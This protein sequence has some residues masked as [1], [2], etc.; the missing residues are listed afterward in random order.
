MAAVARG[1]ESAE[2]QRAALASAAPTKA[3]QH[4]ANQTAEVAAAA[5]L[6]TAGAASPS[7]WMLH[8]VDCHLMPPCRQIPL[9]GRLLQQLSAASLQQ[10][11]CRLDFHTPEN[12]AALCS[13]TALRYRMLQ[14]HVSVNAA[15]GP[16]GL[17]GCSSDVLGP[18]SALQQLMVLKLVLDHVPVQ[19]LAHLKLPQLTRLVAGICRAACGQPAQQQQQQQQASIQQ[20][21]TR[22]LQL[23]LG[24][25]MSLKHLEVKG[26][27]L[28]HSDQ[29]PISLVA[30]DWTFGPKDDNEDEDNECSVQPLLKLTRLEELCMTFCEVPPATAQ[31]RELGSLQQVKALSIKDCS[32]GATFAAGIEQAWG[33]LPLTRLELSGSTDGSDSHPYTIMPVSALQML[34]AMT[35]LESLTLSYDRRS[36]SFG[37]GYILL[38]VTFAQLAATLRPLTA[39]QRLRLI[40]AGLLGDALK[41][42][43]KNQHP[44]KA[45]QDALGWTQL[46]Q[47]Q[48]MHSAGANEQPALCKLQPFEPGSFHSEYG[49][50]RLTSAMQPALFEGCGAATACQATASGAAVSAAAAAAGA[51]GSEVQAALLSHELVRQDQDVLL[52]LLQSCKELHPEVAHQCAGQMTAVLRPHRAEHAVAFATWL[53]RHAG[54]LQVL[55]LQL[56][57]KRAE[58]VNAKQAVY[59]LVG[60]MFEQQKQLQGLQRFYLT[61]SYWAAGILLQLPTSLKVLDLTGMDAASYKRV[62]ALAPITRLQQLTEQRIGRVRPYQLASMKLPP[63]LHQLDVRVELGLQHSA[64]LGLADWLRLHGRKVRYLRL[65]GLGVDAKLAANIDSEI[66]LWGTAMEAVA[67]GLKSAEEQLAVLASA[68]PSKPTANQTAKATAARLHNTDAAPQSSWKMQALDCHLIC[69]SRQ[70]PLPGLLLR[71]L[72]AASLMRLVCGLDFHTPE[73][74][75]AL[76][77][78]TALRY[79]VVQPQQSVNAG[80]RGLLGCSSNVLGPMSSLQQLTVLKLGYVSV[81]QLAHLKLPQL[82]RLVAYARRAACG[83]TAEQQQQQQPPASIEQASARPLQLQLGHLTS[84]T[85]LERSG[86]FGRG[87]ILLCATFEH[88]A[89]VLQPLTALQHLRLVNVGL[90]GDTLKT[91]DH[92]ASPWA[93]GRG[94]QLQP[95]RRLRS[96]DERPMFCVL[97]HFKLGEYHR[98]PGMLT[99]ASAICSLPCLKAVELQLPVKLQSLTNWPL[100][101]MLRSVALQEL[102]QQLVQV[103]QRCCH[104][105][106]VE[107]SLPGHGDDYVLTARGDM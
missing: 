28:L 46:Q 15:A 51:A 57:G 68:S 103:L 73:H 95:Q 58:D 81:Q 60:A 10:L 99:L 106:K 53:Q 17:L 90:L 98:G 75:A 4:T 62:L 97:E 39:L 43:D 30:V 33:V 13:L 23:Q 35:M 80:P 25:L 12:L 96:A 40:N 84:L 89:A 100:A 26:G 63:L 101:D 102:Q 74:L 22:P 65:D 37:R 6:H 27:I 61:S 52:K 59:A 92:A 67:Q 9:P 104:F 19:Q 3:G 5:A 21:S 49:M 79:L 64:L 44:A 71:Q 105:S 36:D 2:Q 7:S 34:A 94:L 48:K 42:E 88:L 20:A 1:L 47:Q 93:A 70:I 41:S 45:Q 56:P 50:L 72:P 82:Q 14:P 24:H 83:H 69:A 77:S 107:C 87:G 66:I 54:L 86:C 16:R 55:K 29:L 85:H 8:T 38:D 18:M 76:C 31:L 91:E 32:G 11:S 78:L